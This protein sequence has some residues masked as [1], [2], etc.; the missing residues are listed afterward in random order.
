MKFNFR[1]LPA[2]PTPAFPD[3][4][5]ILI[6]QI[7]IKLKNNTQEFE[8]YALIDSGAD[9]CVFNAFI[10]EKMISQLEQY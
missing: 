10:G 8:C 4:K 2:D 1:K 9:C 7:R 6:P 5:N 3:R